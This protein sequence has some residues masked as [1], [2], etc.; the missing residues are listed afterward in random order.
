MLVSKG[1]QLITVN[2][3]F[4]AG[5]IRIGLIKELNFVNHSNA[6]ITNTFADC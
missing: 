1:D 6:V 5:K 3:I 4:I 2:D